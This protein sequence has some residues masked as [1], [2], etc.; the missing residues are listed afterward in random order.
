MAYL[1]LTHLPDPVMLPAKHFQPNLLVNCNIFFNL[2]IFF[3]FF[4]VQGLCDAVIGPT[5][6]DLK[7]LYKTDLD[8]IS[9]IVLLRSIGALIGTFLGMSFSEK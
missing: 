2:G 6:L 7:E 8:Q 3:F 4:I 9:F 5:L 1:H